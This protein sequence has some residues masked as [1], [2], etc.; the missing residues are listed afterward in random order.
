MLS[1]FFIERPVLANVLSIVMVVLGIVAVFSL[2]VSQY[3]NIVPPTVMV[4]AR[5]PGASPQTIV[6]TVAL[7]IELQ[8]NGVDGMLYMQ[9]TAAA[10]GTYQLIVTFK[11]GVDPDQAQV[12]VQ[13]RVSNALA[14]LPT[15]VQSQGVTVMKRSTA[16]LE[17]ITLESPGATYDSSF[18]S[19]YATINIVNELARLPGVA[20][21]TVFGASKY[22]MRVWMDPRKLY[23]F[24]LVPQDV[25][26]AISQQ[27]QLVAAGQAGMPPAP[28]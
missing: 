10:D 14:Q 19:N 4:T 6:D 27:S 16:M 23:S 7:P 5:Y 2:P 20:N 9:S 18:L 17:V 3:P 8:V 28:A 25:I 12:R 11:I 1:K 22:A 13:N 24:G 15:P 26:K 21:V